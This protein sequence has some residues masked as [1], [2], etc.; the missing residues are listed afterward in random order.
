M[1]D[2]GIAQHAAQRVAKAAVGRVDGY[3]V[4]GGDPAG[5]MARGNHSFVRFITYSRAAPPGFRF[6]DLEHTL[7]SFAFELCVH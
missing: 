4:E 2:S 5:L 6:V 3:T 1:C 7:I